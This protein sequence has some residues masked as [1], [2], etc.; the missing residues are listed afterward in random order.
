MAEKVLKHF[1]SNIVT[2]PSSNR[3]KWLD[4]RHLGKGDSKKCDEL[5]I[6]KGD[7]F[8]PLHMLCLRLIGNLE[9]YDDLTFLDVFPESTCK[10]FN[11]WIY[12]HL[13]GIYSN[14]N[15]TEATSTITKIISIWRN[16]NLKDNCTKYF[17][18]FIG[19]PQYKKM[20]ELYDYALNYKYLLLGT[21]K[22]KLK[23]TTEENAYIEDSIRLYQEVK[24]D[25][26]T[27][28]DEKGYCVVIDDI[29]KEFSMGELS[30]LKCHEIKESLSDLSEETEPEMDFETKSARAED[31][32]PGIG[33]VGSPSTHASPD[34]VVT[35]IFPA[36]GVPLILF[37]LYKF[38]P[39]G[40]WFKDRLQRNQIIEYNIH[41]DS[42]H[43]LSENG[44]LHSNDES[45]SFINH[46]GYLPS[47]MN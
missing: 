42:S 40:T 43:E 2:L 31:P 34:N 17:I 4:M 19:Y 24:Q 3:Y 21:D 46:I 26:S 6:K 16:F 9:K 41:E 27:D 22:D 5:Y 30:T 37:I 44:F 11:L 8:D 13:S 12:E 25:C 29:E 36:L 38:T 32:V 23:C 47:D 20:K 28:K 18:S 45:E 14:M 1:K 15:D 35:G 39:F 7:D 33:G 10:Y